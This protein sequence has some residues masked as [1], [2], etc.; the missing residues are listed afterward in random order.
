MQVEEVREQEENK[1]KG[2]RVALTQ[3]EM[4]EKRGSPRRNQ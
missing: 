1:E 4:R 3:R 2:G